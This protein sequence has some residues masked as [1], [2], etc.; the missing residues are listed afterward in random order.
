MVSKVTP[1]SAVSST[2]TLPQATLDLSS[3]LLSLQASKCNPPLE[4]GDQIIYI[5]GKSVTESSHDDVILMIKAS[6]ESF[7]PELVLIVK[8]K[9]LT[10]CAIVCVC[11]CVCV[12]VSG[13]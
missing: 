11:V 6:M 13:F 9:D 5:N 1:D 4:E 8:P 3:P 12:C 2:V 10:R 7:P